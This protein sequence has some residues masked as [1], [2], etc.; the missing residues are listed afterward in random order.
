MYIYTY[1]AEAVSLIFQVFPLLLDGFSKH[2]YTCKY[3]LLKQNLESDF[4]YVGTPAEL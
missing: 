1:C 4:F 2:L 3:E